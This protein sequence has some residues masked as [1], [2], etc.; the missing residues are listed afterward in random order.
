MN[1]NPGMVEVFIALARQ[2]SHQ[3]DTRP[4]V[5]SPGK[6]AAV[7]TKYQREVKALVQ[8]QKI[9]A[10]NIITERSANSIE[11]KALIWWNPAGGWPLAHFHI[12]DKIYPANEIQWNT[13]CT[14]VLA[15]VGAN[16]QKA[17]VQV[18]FEEFSQITQ[19]AQNQ[20]T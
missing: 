6:I 11:E 2:V 17:N 14:Q 9:Q 15:K 13:F 18:S 3:V 4:G 1:I 16:L 7:W 19:G 10:L 5:I 12:G 20:M 8:A